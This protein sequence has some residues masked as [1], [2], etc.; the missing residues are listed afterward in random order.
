MQPMPANHER[1]LLVHYGEIGLKGQNQADFRRRLRA[2]VRHRLRA[3]GLGWPVRESPGF[4]SVAVPSDA[5]AGALDEAQ[6]ALGTVFG[7]AWFA[8]ARRIEHARFRPETREADWSRLTAALLALAHERHETG[9]TFAVRVNRADKSLPFTSAE[10]DRQLGA[11]VLQHT[12]WTRVNLSRPDVTFH[13]DLRGDCAYVFADK[14]RGPGGLPVG[15]AGRVLALLSGGIDSPVAAW[16]M[17]KR[18]CEVDFIHFTVAHET[19]DQ[20]RQSKVFRLAQRLSE[21]TLGGRLYFVPYTYFDLALL[22][23]RADYDLVLFRRFMARVAE[24][25]ARR[26]GAQALVSG[27]NLAQVASQTLPN[28]VSTSRAAELPVLRPLL[29]YDKEEIVSLAK[30]IGTY[31]LS[32]EPYK[33]C[34]A[35]ISRHPRTSSRHERLVEL[36]TRL[37]PDYEGLIEQTLRD[38]VCLDIGIRQS[39]SGAASSKDAPSDEGAGRWADSGAGEAP[40]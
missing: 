38:A 30:R 4:L 5:P 17:A 23:E 22:R 12:P 32:I 24:R 9:Q 28:L 18:G 7:V 29:T 33:D 14:R 11:L 1:T 40:G 27:D 20:A 2:N 26:L 35:L 37:L 3:L 13:V 16:L 36:E 8:L 10:L 39:A 21:A 34:C 25:L 15:T 6:A 19:P 31:A